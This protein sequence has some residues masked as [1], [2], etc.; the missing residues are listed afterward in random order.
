MPTLNLQPAAEITEQSI[1]RDLESGLLMFDDPSAL[2]LVL[3]D[4]AT[5]DNFI[6]QNNWAA[7]WDQAAIILQSPKNASVFEGSSVARANVSDFMLSDI[8]SSLVP[9][10]MGGIFYGDPPFILR[11]RPGTS[12]DII[13]AKSALFSFQL[14]DMKFEEEVERGIEQMALFGTGIWKYGW[15][16]ETRKVKTYKRVE[17]PPTIKTPFMTHDVHTEGSDQFTVTYDDKQIQRPWLKYCDIRT[18]LVD[19]G[20][21][22]G[23]IRRA[24]YVVYRDY[25]TYDDLNALRGLEGYDIPSE[26]VL[27]S[28]FLRPQGIPGG[29]NLPMVIP[30]TMRGWLQ[31]ALPRNVR[32]TADPLA[33][34]LEILERWDSD[35]VIVVLRHQDDNILIRNEANPFAK[36]PFLSANWRNIPDSFYGQGLGLIVGGKQLVKQGVSNL[37]LDMMAYTLNPTTLRKKGWNTPSQNTR[38][39]LGGIIDVDADDVG[40]AFQ[41]LEFPE[42]P[43][44]AFSFMQQMMADAQTSSGANEQVSMGAGSAGVKTTGM[45]T[46]SGANAVVAANASRLDGPTMRFIRQV[47]V[48][49]LWQ[50]D[51]LNNDLLPTSVLRDVLNEEMGQQFKVDHEQFRKA[52]IEYEVLA[53]AKLGAKAQMA[54]YLP[55]VEQMM[56]NPTI[57]QMAHDQ[58]Y[59]WNF[60]AF[61]NAMSDLAGWKFS[62]DFL[63][64]MNPQEKQQS[65]A[66]SP[67]ALQAQKGQQVEALE[68]KKFENKEQLQEEGQLGRA[69]GELMRQAV[70]QSG[71]SE[72]VN[73]EPGSK[74]FGSNV[75]A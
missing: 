24:K 75:E 63:V 53:G 56:N 35:R 16:E 34:G 25:A 55:F 68:Q 42:P 40:K 27:K 19:P 54:Q 8:I 28:F 12:Q 61:F 1:K 30:A 26:E 72:A 51:D 70:E 71:E 20:C 44:V 43:Q 37:S 47:F 52:K 23:D 29:D 48:P 67:A 50:M 4:A 49:W 21:R 57:V 39:R 59:K 5:C 13:R 41:V 33:N 60:V 18:V 22:Y 6:T 32:S 10:M 15:M 11:P 58:G 73:G 46:A 14:D 17:K 65:Q 2:K 66:N 45:R 31:A 7:G 3:D 74:G 36:I 69:G 64:P 62:Q 9:K 38:V